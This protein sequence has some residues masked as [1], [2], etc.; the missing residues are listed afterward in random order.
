MYIFRSRIRD[1][2]SKIRKP[3]ADTVTQ[4]SPKRTLPV[5][6]RKRDANAAVERCRNGKVLKRHRDANMESSQL[7]PNR[8]KEK[9]PPM[10]PTNLTHESLPE[11]LK[12]CS[13]DYTW[14]KVEQ[15]GRVRIDRN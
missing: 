9:I 5:G 13:T 4:K 11:H 15:K 10:Q 1:E 14:T 7:T 3:T 12:K 6:A 2:L 8:E